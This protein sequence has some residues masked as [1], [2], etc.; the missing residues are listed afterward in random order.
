MPTLTSSPDSPARAR[1]VAALHE[2][3]AA[4]SVPQG[5]DPA[6]QAQFAELRFER[7]RLTRALKD[8]ERSATVRAT[9]VGSQ[10]GVGSRV[11]LEWAPGDR[12]WVLL[13]PDAEPPADTGSDG[14]LVVSAQAPLGA[15]LTGTE[16]GARVVWD[17]PAGQRL[18]ATVVSVDNGHGPATGQ[19]AA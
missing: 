1:L 7:D 9:R 4:L 19:V 8:L 10:A 6:D 18:S 5:G 13:L 12:E 3:D 11:E 16:P 15:A 17:T 14:T 2:V